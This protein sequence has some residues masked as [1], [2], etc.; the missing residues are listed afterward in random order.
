[1]GRQ[2]EMGEL[3]AALDD[4][5]SG[6]GRLAMLVGEPGIGKTRTAQELASYAE[7]LGVQVLWGRCYEEE[8][9]PPYW[10]WLQSLRFYIQQQTP[11]LLLTEMGPGAADIAEILP[12]LREKLTGL[13]TPPVLEPEQA[14]FRLFDSITTFLKNAAQSQ[15]LMLVLDDLHWADKPSLLLLQFLT[16]EMGG[17]RLLVVGT[18][19]DVELSRQHPLSE[20]LAHLSREPV[21]RREVMG[22]LS[23]KDTGDF[24]EVAAGLRPPPGLVE[25]IYLQTEG[26]PFFIGEI[27]RLL[28]Q[29][30]ELTE[31]DIG[32]SPTIRIPEGVRE[33]I[34]QRLNRL[35]EQCN[36]TLVT[37]A[38]IGREFD[39]RLLSPL[40]DD[41]DE[42]SLLGLVEEAL[43]SHV[44]EEL[45]ES[46]ERYQ[47]S[48]A[49][50][51][52]TLLGEVSSSRRTRLHARI[53]EA[54]E[55]IYG[56]DTEAHAAELAHHFVEAETV[57]G[58]D[59]L[60]HYSL[61]AGERALATYAW[62][63]A[64]AH[65]ECAL[66]AKGVPLSSQDPA[67]DIE[68]AT[69][70]FG[71]ARAQLATT[72]RHEMLQAADTLSRAFNY[73]ADAGDVERTVEVAEYPYPP[74][75]GLSHGVTRLIARALELVPAESNQAGRLLSRYGYLLG[76]EEGDYVGAQDAFAGA[77]S[78]AE[79]EN[80]T[81]LEMGT[82]ANAAQVDRQHHDR[83][84]ALR[85]SL[86]AI[87]L[88]RQHNDLFVEVAARH[89]AAI[90]L[91]ETGELEQARRH[92]LV[93]LEGAERLRDRFWLSSALNQ[94]A[95]L[96]FLMGD[97]PA[98]RDFSDRGLKVEPGDSRALSNRA[99]LEYQVGDFNQ[100]SVYL[101][102]LLEIM[103]RTPPGPTAPYARSALVIPAIA[104]ISSMAE[105]S[106]VAEEAAQAVLS[107]SSAT[108]LHTGWAR[109]GLALMTVLRVDAA[110][111]WEQYTTMEPQRGAMLGLT[112]IA[113]DRLLGLLAQ[114]M[115]NL[116]Q[117]MSDFEDALAFCRRANYRPE[118]AW[119]CCDYADC[120]IQRNE[121]GDREKAV[122][123]LD[124][125]LSI[126]TE[127][128]MIPLMERVAALQERAASQPVGAPLF[129]DR[130]TQREVEV[131]QL[132]AAGK[133]DR[134]IADELFISVRTVGYHVGNILNK[135]TS[136]NRTE[137][138]TY[139]SRNG[140]V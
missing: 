14:R 114:T 97:W 5:L 76:L 9:A 75:F 80:D 26:N 128:G 135:T 88:A 8:G 54:L 105:R 132:I 64:Q 3:K 84:E 12:E 48:H 104:R 98:A 38:V 56:A 124:E 129:P 58:T 61:L 35:S 122:S 2:R 82:L 100:G 49:L 112:V 77:L 21:F 123:L 39:F 69:L 83:P 73:Y 44:L 134:E 117:A 60:V 19:R 4:A 113:S 71:L 45:P 31:V 125:S 55:E 72:E 91:R 57:L 16:R 22:G 130:L 28:A 15:P 59:K 41:L 63:E 90:V 7:T 33:V 24:V 74:S 81:I 136:S 116:D 25:G 11:E 40:M 67:K 27:I 111:A 115:G 107:S 79:R 103:R 102:R 108:P 131:L 85:K 94:N 42:A 99:V 89:E 120:L 46:R 23:R 78:I 29:Q 139:A 87:E 110:T 101:E 86:R 118:L 17:S 127:L 51:Q 140:L 96:C 43:D 137:A 133:T 47:F 10:P 37:A 138:A 52:E 109:V 70:L 106:D 36:R 53:A 126:S 13:E 119:A 50:I 62:E 95:M 65:F 6:Q 30:G 1:M 68:A 32:E 66:L 121:P 20:T 93:E 34:G 18:Y 92:A